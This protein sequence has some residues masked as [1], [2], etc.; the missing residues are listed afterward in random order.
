MTELRRESAG[1]QRSK[2]AWSHDGCDVLQVYLVVTLDMLLV[3]V[4]KRVSEG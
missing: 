2:C 4:G 3:G 1:F